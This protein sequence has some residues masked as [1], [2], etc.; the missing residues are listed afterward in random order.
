MEALNWIIRRGGA[1]QARP[2]STDGKNPEHPMI[3]AN[4]ALIQGES[5]HQ[6]GSFMPPIRVSHAINK[7]RD[8]HDK[9]KVP[10][11]FK[12]SSTVVCPK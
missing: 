7:G 6:Q 9:R 10:R 12:K 3:R 8:A 5:C 1:R 2:I 4:H 11:W